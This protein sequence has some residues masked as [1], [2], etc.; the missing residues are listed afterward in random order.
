LNATQREPTRVRLP[1]LA[2]ALLV[3]AALAWHFDFVCDDAFISFRYARHLAEGHGLVFNLGRRPPVEGYS[4]FLWVLLCTLFELLRL[5]PDVA[6]RVVS[7]ACGALLVFRVQHFAAHRLGL[8][9]G[10]QLATGMFLASLPPM[11]VWA[12]SGLETMATA[13]CVFLA[14]EAL[15]G[16]PQR[17]RGMRAGMWMLATALLRADGAA[18]GLLLLACALGLWR[19]RGRSPELARAALAA[20]ALLVAGVA[21]HVLWRHSYYGYWVPNTARVKAGFSFIRLERGGLYLATVLMA[22]PSIL[23]LAGVSLRRFRAE[24]AYIWGPTLAFLVAAAGYA[25]WVGGD[26]MPFGRFLMP[27]VPF[28]PLLLACLLENSR[29]RGGFARS[30]V[31]LAS[32]VCPLLSLLASFD[33]TPFPES[34]RRRL[35]FRLDRRDELW[36][37]EVARWRDM[38]ANTLRWIPLGRALGRHTRLG[39]SMIIGG[40]GAQAYYSELFVYDNYGLVTPE[41]VE[42][43]R[44]RE[45]SSPGHDMKVSDEF[46]FFPPHG[47]FHDRITY[48]GAAILASPG[49]R[50]SPDSEVPYWAFEWSDTFLQWWGEQGAAQLVEEELIPLSTEDG[51]PEGSILVLMRFIWAGR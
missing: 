15:L 24:Q 2:A 44:I 6:S 36:Q 45:R 37:S 38:R 32:V 9:L 21:V 39:E 28:L 43:G 14:Y 20:G 13:T 17:P 19:F 8:G 35:D 3:Y 11:G 41:V 48:R 50:E 31:V 1:A 40:M 12:T 29:G 25:L 49:L 46:F 18:W 7:V 26:F 30:S 34:L 27:A 33:V 22:V 16:D 10:G 51:F 47:K 5:A 23:L 42:R 4:N